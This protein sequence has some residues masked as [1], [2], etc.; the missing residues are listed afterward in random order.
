[1]LHWQMLL[2]VTE[3]LD[4]FLL[5]PYYAGAHDSKSSSSTTTKIQFLLPINKVKPFLNYIAV[6]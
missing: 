2:I 5:A 3:V 1:M 6:C 4:T